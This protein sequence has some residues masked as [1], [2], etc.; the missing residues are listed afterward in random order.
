[1]KVL[2]LFSGIGGFS[3]GLERAGMETIA[4]CEY[5]EK[6]RQVLKKHWPDVPIHEDVRTLDGRQY[7]G[8]IELIC[9]G[10]PC[11]PFSHAGKR[12]GKE[13]DR[14]LWPEFF[15]L[16]REIKPN[17]VIAENVAGHIN[18]GLDEVLSDLEGEGYTWQPFII[19]A[20][21]I[22]APHRRDRVW[23]VAN[24]NELPGQI[25]G[26]DQANEEE[27]RTGSLVGGECRAD[28]RWKPVPEEDGL[29]ANPQG[30]QSSPRNNRQKQGSSSEQG[31]VQ[32]G[33]DGGR[34]NFGQWDVEPRMGRVA[35]RVPGG[36]D[37]LKQL[38]NAVVPQ[39]VEIIGRAIM[40]TENR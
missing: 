28:D 7:H 2:D 10:Y 9:G 11:Q 17:W 40:E 16:I 5:D 24:H 15:R 26:D 39:I 20:C 25:G 36:L 4:F 14:H 37:R 27:G 6:C 21:A 13:D 29:L 31:Q 1:M 22:N 35:P 8:A 3:L 34:H 23:I 30:K 19:P 18:M 32:L 12:K 38:G 33:R